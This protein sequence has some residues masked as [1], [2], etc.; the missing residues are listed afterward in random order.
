MIEA[1]VHA[2]KPLDFRSRLSQWGTDFV[3]LFQW[4]LATGTEGS[5]SPQLK[6][7]I[8]MG[9]LLCMIMVLYCT[10]Y[11]LLYT[12]FGAHVLAFV[13]ETGILVAVASMV[14]SHGGRH[15]LAR[16]LFFTYA[17]FLIGISV[18]MWG[19]QYN[20]QL[21]YFPMA[22]IPFLL[23]TL[24]ERR[25]L[26]ATSGLAVLGYFLC[27]AGP[28]AWVYHLRPHDLSPT[29]AEIIG[30][31]T[32]CASLLLLVLPVAVIF[33]SMRSY[34]EE[35]HSTNQQRLE[36]E[37]NISIGQM[38]GTLAHEINSPLTTILG[39]MEMINM[40]VER[41]KLD[42]E[43]LKKM[44]DRADSAVKKITSITQ[45]LRNLH[46]TS[47]NDPI[48]ET[49]IQEIL[50]E[51]LAIVLPQMHKKEVALVQDP[52]SARLP[53]HCRKYQVFQA[54]LHLFEFAL[55]KIPKSQLGATVEVSWADEQD[56]VE[57]FI[58]FSG[59]GLSDEMIA[60][61]NDSFFT[62]SSDHRDQFPGL[63]MASMIIQRHQGSLKLENSG[64]NPCFVLQLPVRPAEDLD[65]P[66]S[67]SLD[68]DALLKSS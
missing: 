7:R 51:V 33:R 27:Q 19:P 13:T 36:V 25:S 42:P 63:I 61:I 2:P 30:V 38:A 60:N 49:S 40:L 22:V 14:L 45:M 52:S 15:L 58:R 62:T 32:E 48:E 43:K 44:T 59:E 31:F 12:Y 6:S 54:I 24:H 17:L 67:E 8:R 11:G 64:E 26:V 39:A 55:S 41:N 57:L 21:I 68:V 65:S 35:I 18:Q 66:E 5:K 37:K 1:S 56:S 10:A 4:L 3:T 29:T 34:E 28:I 53:V 9:N 47:G 16:H 46:Y 23:F 50:A 20:I